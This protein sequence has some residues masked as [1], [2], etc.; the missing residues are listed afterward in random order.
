MLIA[1]TPVFSVLFKIAGLK[2]PSY[3]FAA[4]ISILLLAYIY[5]VNQRVFIKKL[6]GTFIVFCLCMIFSVGI[7]LPWMAHVAPTEK[8]INLIYV[9]FSPIIVV[10]LGLIK[11]RFT[12]NSKTDCVNTIFYNCFLISSLLLI[13][14]FIFFR[15]PDGDGRFILPGLENPI[16][17]SR[18]LAAGL[19]VFAIHN[20]VYRSHY[21]AVTILFSVLLLIVLI[22]SGS[23]GPVVALI[24]ALL[25]FMHNTKNIFSAKI[26]F[27]GGVLVSSLLVIR[28]FSASY[29]FDTEFFSLYHRWDAINFVFDESFSLVGH[30]LS[31][32]G[33]YYFNE[34]IDIYPHNLLVELYFEYGLFGACVFLIITYAVLKTYKTSLPGVLALYYYINSLFSGDVPGNAPLFISLI[35]AWVI[36]KHDRE[37]LKNALGKK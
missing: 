5:S 33:R 17:V 26:I 24:I 7:Y 18:H 29:I 4:S 21:T 14:A 32:F 13:I 34:D 10:A 28:A 20:F 11:L 37:L 36:I 19:L 1:F 30:G 27:F 22:E 2:I 12:E 25:L 15:I 16:W 8:L 9:V 35:V 23:R 6:Y 3:L 31:S